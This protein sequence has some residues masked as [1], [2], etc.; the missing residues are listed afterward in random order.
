MEPEFPDVKILVKKQLENTKTSVETIISFKNCSHPM[1]CL[2]TL[3]L[4]AVHIYENYRED[5]SKEDQKRFVKK[6]AELIQATFDTKPCDDLPFIRL[7][8]STTTIQ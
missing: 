8:N 3:A 4:A 2:N 6:F 7:N 1:S 5:K